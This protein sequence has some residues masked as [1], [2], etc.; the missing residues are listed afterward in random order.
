M[1]IDY[2]QLNI[3]LNTP[4]Y[5]KNIMTSKVPSKLGLLPILIKPVTKDG[6][7]ELLMLEIPEFSY[8]MFQ[9]PMEFLKTPMSS[10][11]PTVPESNSSSNTSGGKN[12]R[13][14]SEPALK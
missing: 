9:P 2:E 1:K 12:S 4:A 14:S 8:S 11:S 13:N 3:K 10:Q 6:N 5:R 7:P